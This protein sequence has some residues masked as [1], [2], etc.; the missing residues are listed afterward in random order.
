MTPQRVIAVVA[1]GLLTLS[2]CAVGGASGDGDNG[3]SKTVTVYSADGLNSGSPSWYKTQF[4]AFTKSTGIKVDYIEAGS[5]EVVSRAQTE[6]ANPQADVLVTLPPFIMTAASEG[7]LTKYTPEG[8]EAIDAS[9]KDPDGKWYALVNNYPDFIY[10]TK[11]MSAPPRTLNDLLEPKFKNKLQYSTPGQAGDGTAVLI[12]VAHMLGSNDAALAYFTKLQ[13]NNVGPSSSTG[14]L[15]AKVNHGDLLVANGDMQM[16]LAQLAENPNIGL[17]FISDKSGKKSTFSLP[18][19]MGLV[20]DGPH[21]ENGKKLMDFLLT[22]EVQTTVSSI[23]GGFSVRDDVT[24]TDDNATK[25][26][27]LME[28]VEIWAPD[29]NQ[30]N[31]EL[32]QLIR[33]WQQATRK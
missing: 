27:S 7:V 20:T 32:P 29:W 31:D 14:K 13:S 5:A 23:G 16:N 30:I 9:L 3:D 22:K 15:T 24:A 18:Y 4:A 1:G 21:T 25:L 19:S 17:F 6:K 33:K 12:N 2:A 26:K 28:G 11:S 8:A 10:N